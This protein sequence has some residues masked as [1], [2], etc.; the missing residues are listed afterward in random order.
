M[1]GRT[2]MKSILFSTAL[3]GV[4]I[5][6]SSAYPAAAGTF[7]LS[8][9]DLMSLD[10]YPNSNPKI[11]PNAPRIVAKRDI[12]GPGVEFDIYFPPDNKHNNVLTYVS[13]SDRGKG[14]LAGIDVNDFDAFAL[15]FTLVAVDGKSDADAGGMLVV[16]ALVSGGYRPECISFA[17]SDEAISITADNAKKISLIGFEVH[18]LTPDGWNPQGN[19]VTIR[20]EA[21][22]N[23]EML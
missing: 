4:C 19:T 6:L 3:T 7:T 21:A 20:V 13:C 5:L 9:T 18:K 16:G 1:K 15:K 8:D 17:K 22:P 2:M 23:A 11:D 12:P 14:T 10:V